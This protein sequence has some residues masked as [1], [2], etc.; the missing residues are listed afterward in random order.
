M[1]RPRL[2]DYP[3]VLHPINPG[4]LRPSRVKPRN[5]TSLAMDAELR[6]G[7][8]KIALGIFVDA[9]NAGLPFQR[10]LLA[11][12]LSGIDHGAKGTAP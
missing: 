10:A 12:Y 2:A 7:L 3:S 9:S 11:V 4:V 5:M 1:S 6:M 8:E